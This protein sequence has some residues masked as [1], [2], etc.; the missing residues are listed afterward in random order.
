[1]TMTYCSIYFAGLWSIVLYNMTAGVLCA[2]GDSKN[3]LYILMACSILNILGGFLLVGI[4]QLG[5][6][7]TAIS[8]VFAQSVSAGCALYMLSKSINKDGSRIILKP[9]FCKTHMPKMLKIGFPL[10]LQSIMFP[11]ATQLFR[12]VSIKLA[13]IKLLHGQCVG[14]LIC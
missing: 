8:T 2:F 3:P 13:Q 4:F 12:P 9:K 7:G 6:S 1:M 5:V 14:S 10:A 11:V